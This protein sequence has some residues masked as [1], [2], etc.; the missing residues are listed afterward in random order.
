MGSFHH[1][2]L[3]S[4]VKRS[5]SQRNAHSGMHHSTGVLNLDEGVVYPRGELAE[6]V[7][8]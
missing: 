1:R 6:T 2:S 3:A 8:S 4:E 5:R 7:S